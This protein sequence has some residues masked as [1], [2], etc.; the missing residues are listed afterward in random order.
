MTSILDF[1][2]ELFDAGY[3]YRTIN[4][5][6]FAISAYHQTIDGKGVSSNKRV[7]K[8]LSKV[9]NLGPPQPK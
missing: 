9:F 4:S 2:G 5:Y 6:R 3:D 8:L 7:C 1:L